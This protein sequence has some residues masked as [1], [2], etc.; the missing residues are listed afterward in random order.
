MAL[1]RKLVSSQNIY[2]SIIQCEGFDIYD[3]IFIIVKNT[4]VYKILFCNNLHLNI[5]IF[6][7]VT[8]S[9]AAI[10]LKYVTCKNLYT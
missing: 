10:M 5:Y 2:S 8:F 6:V 1:Y 3:G 9:S 7:A 4:V